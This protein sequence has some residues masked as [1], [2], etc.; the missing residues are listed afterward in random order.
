L[1]RLQRPKVQH[2]GSMA[3]IDFLQAR[4]TER[5]IRCRTLLETEE[6]WGVARPSG[7]A[8]EHH[9]KLVCNGLSR[10]LRG[11]AISGFGLCGVNRDIHLAGTVRK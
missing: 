5:E 7:P 11:T 4:I 1:D 8:R 2:T 3:L 6:L 10:P 9:L